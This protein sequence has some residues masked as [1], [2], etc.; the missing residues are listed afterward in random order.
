MI[1]SNSYFQIGNSHK[2]C[3]DFALHYHDENHGLAI[4]CDGCSSSGILNGM[5]SPINVDFGSRI[6]A[7]I[8]KNLINEFGIEA[9]SMMSFNNKNKYSNSIFC[10]LK[11]QILTALNSMDI[12]VGVLDS[13]CIVAGMDNSGKGRV[14]FLGDGVCVFQS[15]NFWRICVVEYESGAPYYISY[16]LSESRGCGY[17]ENFGKNSKKVTFYNYYLDTNT[18]VK[19]CEHITDSQEYLVLNFNQNEI[20]YNNVSVFSDGI[21]TFGTREQIRSGKNI[22]I[23]KIIDILCKFHNIKG[24]FVIKRF[25]LLNNWCKENSIN[26]YDDLSMSCVGIV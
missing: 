11:L 25:N 5:R 24:E 15:K 12:P 23:N 2:F 16:L 18:F 14:A 10:N 20:Q 4:V 13:T 17:S 7:N 3:E 9:I 21:H 26:H 19:D 6:L 22:E 1:S 8:M